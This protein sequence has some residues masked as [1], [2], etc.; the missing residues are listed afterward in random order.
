MLMENDGY[1]EYIIK[2][3]KIEELEQLYAIF[4]YL[5]K[6][7]DFDNNGSRMCV[8]INNRKAMINIYNLDITNFKKYLEELIEI[9]NNILTLIK[10]E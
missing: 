6:Q 2:A 10:T 8:E 3:E 7:V 5:L 9:S 1:R 4:E